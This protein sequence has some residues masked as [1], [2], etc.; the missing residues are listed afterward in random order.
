MR[1]QE[2]LVIV[3]KSL[4]CLRILVDLQQNKNNMIKVWARGFLRP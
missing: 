3:Q 4:M 1:E 2:L